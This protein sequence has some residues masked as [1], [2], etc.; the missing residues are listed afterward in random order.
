[1]GCLLK[2]FQN[3]TN[4]YERITQK[5]IIPIRVLPEN[6]YLCPKCNNFPEIL[7]ISAENGSIGLKCKEHDIIE[8][9]IN[10]FLDKCEK[11]KSK[12][13][14]DDENLISQ[15]VKYCETCQEYINDR[16]SISKHQNHDTINLS[17]LNDIIQRNNFIEKIREK[18]NEL[19]NNIRFNTIII[20]SYQN[21]KQNYNHIKSVINL[22]KSI[23]IENE[24][25]S[26]YIEHM[27]QNLEKKLEDEKNDI[28]AL[29]EKEIQLS[30]DE[31][32][33]ILKNR[34]LGDEGLKS[35]SKIQFKNLKEINLSNN[36]IKN[37][38]PLK[39]MNLSNL[40]K[41]DLSF[42][43]IESIQIFEELK[44]PYMKDICL[45]NNKIEDFSPIYNNKCF[46]SLQRLRIEANQKI[47]DLDN[48]KYQLIKKYKKI[49]LYSEI[50]SWDKFVEKYKVEIK[51]SKDS[52]DSIDSKDNKDKKLLDLSDKRAG[53]IIIEELYNIIG[54]DKNIKLRILILR[55]NEINDCSLLSR[56]HLLHL[57]KLDLSVNK[58]KN[59]DFLINMKMPKLRTL[60]L[61][62]NYINKLKPLLN[63]KKIK[64]LKADNEMVK[65][66]KSLEVMSL[67]DNN[68]EFNDDEVKFVIDK[69]NDIKIDLRV[70]KEEKKK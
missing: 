23:K 30:G 28:D 29:K 21:F 10:D 12:K 64:N 47:K 5:E 26:G 7:H 38:E 4:N 39:N 44:A 11:S 25:H 17:L 31:E 70:F 40:R 50:I 56:I 1:M 61:D 42:N 46:R 59:L 37:I 6:H 33:L 24:R 18:N 62:K 57:R 34:K 2:N 27:F 41:I 65:N 15:N 20:N 19:A 16:E 32:I 52:I 58:I 43:K 49:N 67:L 45:Q 48:L 60:F 13:P 69:L 14:K 66:F 22:G 53:D 63:I 36:G 9:Y 3:N 54:N 51:D 55:N 8:L 68:F 35:L